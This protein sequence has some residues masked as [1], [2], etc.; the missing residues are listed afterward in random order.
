MSVENII[1]AACKFIV[2]SNEPITL[3]ELTD[4]VLHYTLPCLNND[5]AYPVIKRVFGEPTARTADG[6]RGYKLKFDGK[7]FLTQK[8]K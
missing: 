3:Q 1:R 5:K 8:F 6:N 7:R 4:S 2:P